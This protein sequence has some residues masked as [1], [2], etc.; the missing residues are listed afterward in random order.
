MTAIHWP[1]RRDGR[2]HVSCYGVQCLVCTVL[3]HTRVWPVVGLT[4]A[5][6]ASLVV[7][8]VYD[9]R[10]SAMSIAGP[11]QASCSSMVAWHPY[12]GGMV[13]VSGTVQSLAGAAGVWCVMHVS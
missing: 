7:S 2:W 11:A 8:E 12:A 5:C 6:T 9:A 1:R 10:G 13:V 3:C 4:V